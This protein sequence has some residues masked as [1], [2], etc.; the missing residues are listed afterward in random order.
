M[1]LTQEHFLS[2]LLGTIIHI[3]NTNRSWLVS[4]GKGWPA[5]EVTRLTQDA[6][7]NLLES[8]PLV[9]VV[10]LCASLDLR[11]ML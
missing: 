6:V 10:M 4:A 3:M 1:P 5:L 11:G 9:E 2:K 7:S 8:L